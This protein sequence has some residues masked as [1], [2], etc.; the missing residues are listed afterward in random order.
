MAADMLYG[1][2]TKSNLP[3]LQPDLCIPVN[4]ATSQPL[5]LSPVLKFN[6]DMDATTL[7]TSTILISKIGGGTVPTYS[8]S[9]LTPSTFKITFSSALDF[10]SQYQVTVKSNVKDLNGSTM[11]ADMLYGFTTLLLPE[12]QPQACIP[13][14]KSDN[15]PVGLSPVLKFNKDMD[16]STL[17]ASTILIAKVGGGTVPTYS[18]SSLT[19][20]TFKITFGQA[21]DFSSQYQV[22]VKSNVKDLNGSSMAS[23]MLYSFK[24]VPIIYNLASSNF[25][26]QVESTSCIGKKTGKIVATITDMSYAYKVSVTGVN[27][28]S[29]TQDIALGTGTWS[30]T[31]LDKGKYTVCIAIA[32]EPNQK[33]CFDVEVTEPAPL[34]VYA[35]VDNSTGIIDLALLGAKT[36]TVSINGK[37]T[38]V[39]S[40]SFTTVLPTGLNTISVTTDKDCQGIYQRE[41]FISEKAIVYPNPTFGVLHLFVGGED[42]SILYSLH[43]LLGATIKKTNLTVGATREVTVDLSGIPQ[44]SYIITINSKTVSQSFK[45]IKL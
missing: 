13:S 14:D 41:I 9:A 12:L 26:I 22:T 37:S 34:S 43:D 10:N 15:Q 40:N 21:L 36:Y 30:S 5:T 31:G 19:P 1:F 42:N 16:A 25:K 7:T 45:V 23:D 20:T 28:Y 18:I 6:K 35:K 38:I 8:I 32:S 4:N 29:T 33:Q 3:E 39:E 44:G 2:T 27:G 24:T 11:A 17:T